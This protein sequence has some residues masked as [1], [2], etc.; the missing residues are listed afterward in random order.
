MVAFNVL[1]SVGGRRGGWLLLM[2]WAGY[3]GG[4]VALSM[5]WKGE[6]RGDRELNSFWFLPL[7]IYSYIKK[8]TTNMVHF[9]RLNVTRTKSLYTVQSTS[10]GQVLS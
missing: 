7:C 4:M 8:V 9:D 10:I 2:F 6:G 3:E 1:G 5:C